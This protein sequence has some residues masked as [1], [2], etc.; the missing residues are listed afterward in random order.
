MLLVVAS[1]FL[2]LG[3]LTFLASFVCSLPWVVEMEGR[4]IIRAE[5]VDSL[6]RLAMCR[7]MDIAG[8]F[9]NLLLVI[10]FIFVIIS[11][12]QSYSG[13]F[14]GTLEENGNIAGNV[15]M[16]QPFSQSQVAYGF[17]F[18]LYG[19]FFFFL[20][21]KFYERKGKVQGHIYSKLLPEMNNRLCGGN[22]D[23]EATI[24]ESREKIVV[25][26]DNE[27]IRDILRVMKKRLYPQL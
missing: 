20:L 25:E 3:L 4:R 24:K 18:F 6:R 19:S 10:L 21:D 26:N 22:T 7:L 9:L 2:A 8:W 14:H 16:S 12:P 17:L 5:S 23:L 11:G 27:A 13:S 15:T 1:V